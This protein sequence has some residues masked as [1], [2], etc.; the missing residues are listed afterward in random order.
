MS[1][2]GWSGGSLPIADR[3]LL[4]QHK[5]HTG[6]Q[7]NGADRC[8]DSR[9]MSAVFAIEEIA[10]GFAAGGVGA[11][12]GFERVGG[13]LVGGFFFAAL[14]AAISESGLSGLEFEFLSADYAG[15]DGVRHV[16]M[17]QGPED[18]ERTQ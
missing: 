10:H 2:A 18:W 5:G 13:L 7:G 3:S 11:F 15:F 4:M 1:G 14:R 6:S 12:I 8:L 17:I 9:F 16:S